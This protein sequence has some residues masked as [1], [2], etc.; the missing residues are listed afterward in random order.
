MSLSIVFKLSDRFWLM[1]A[2][3]LLAV[4]MLVLLL[5]PRGDAPQTVARREPALKLVKKEG[6]EK[7]AAA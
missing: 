5:W 3:I 2:V 7:E 4:L 6:A 1:L